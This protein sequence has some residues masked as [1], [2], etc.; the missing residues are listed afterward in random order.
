MSGPVIDHYAVVGNPVAHSLSPEIHAAFASETGQVLEYQRLLA[1]LDDFAGALR[2]F[3]ES[4][5]KGCNVTVPFKVEAFQLANEKSERAQLAGAA[6]T[7]R[8]EGASL[9][10]DNTDGAGLIADLESN[11]GFAIAGKRVLLLGAGGAARGALGPLLGRAPAHLVIANRTAEKAHALASEFAR[12]GPVSAADFGELGGRQF[13]LV[14]NSTSASIAGD[15][16]PVP[17]SAF[18]PGALAYEMMYGK[19]ETAFLA[20]AARAGARVA[21]GLGML[22]EQAAEAFFVW[23]GVRPATAPVLTALRATKVPRA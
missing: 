11:L 17:A 14:I 9:Y 18:A 3:R 2:R 20:L 13:D 19:G 21:D 1:P 10:A 6:N 22:V 23:R 7:L 8:F 5:A 16:P 4:G 12:L 15:T